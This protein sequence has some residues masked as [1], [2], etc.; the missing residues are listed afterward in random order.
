[1]AHHIHARFL[2][3]SVDIP[4]LGSRS[5]KDDPEPTSRMSARNGQVAG[6]VVMVGTGGTV[7]MAGRIR[8]VGTDFFRVFLG[9]LFSLW[10]FF[11]V[12]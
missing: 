12:S 5:L 8:T 11:A 7:R 9:F 6:A 3:L 1:M 2:A 10:G 4:R